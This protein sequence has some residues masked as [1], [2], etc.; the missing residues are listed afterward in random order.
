MPPKPCKDVTRVGVLPAATRNGL[1]CL[2]CLYVNKASAGE[3]V[4]LCN[5]GIGIATWASTPRTACV[6]QHL[7]ALAQILLL[8]H[9]LLHAYRVC[10]VSVLRQVVQFMLHSCCLPEVE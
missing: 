2:K 1:K 7:T 4:S 8:L 5:D 6:E 10:L 9:V 3:V